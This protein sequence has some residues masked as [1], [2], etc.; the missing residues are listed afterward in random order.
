M[1]IFL[2]QNL[3]LSRI[4]YWLY[5][6]EIGKQKLMSM[7]LSGSQHYCFCMKKNDYKPNGKLSLNLEQKIT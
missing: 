3:R 2:N 4:F 6:F 5:I 7:S 1:V